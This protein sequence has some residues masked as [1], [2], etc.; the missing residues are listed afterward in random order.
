MAM[1]EQLHDRIKA[2]AA[3]LRQ[4]IYGPSGTPR[5]G[6]KFTEI[7]DAGVEVGDAL[8]REL[9]GQGLEAQAAEA[10]SASALAC[11]V[12]GRERREGRRRT[13]RSFRPA[14]GMPCGGSR[15]ACVSIV[16]RLFSPQSQA[17]GIEPDATVGPRVLEKMAYAGTHAT[18]FQQAEGDVKALAELEISAQRIMRA[19]KRIGQERATQREAEVETWEKLTL[20]EQQQSPHAQ[21]PAAACVEIDGGRI[22][23]RD[24]KS[25][26]PVEE[27]SRKG[28]FWRETKV[29]CLTSMSSVPWEEDPCPEI[30]RVFVDPRRIRQISRE[31]KGFSAEGEA[32]ETAPQKW[33]DRPG[34]PEVAVP[35]RCCSW[36]RTT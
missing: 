31:I 35:R 25:T 21:V 23:I 7:E 20:P 16:G 36:P 15:R 13:A 19:T 32:L 22:Q 1:N 5:W 8:A 11:T 2:M 12:C 30:P 27:G 3:E 28:R 10:V 29:G 6:T 17:L 33:E 14:A 24:R 26:Q 9:I 34:R 4:E 18:S